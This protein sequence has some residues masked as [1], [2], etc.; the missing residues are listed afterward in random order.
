[1]LCR[2]FFLTLCYLLGFDAVGAA[3][4]VET[5]VN[6]ASHFPSAQ[7][8]PKRQDEVERLQFQEFAGF[9]RSRN[10][11]NEL[12]ELEYWGLLN[13]H[14]GMTRSEV[15]EAREDLPDALLSLGGVPYEWRFE[16]GE[17]ARLVAVERWLVGALDESLAPQHAEQVRKNR[18]A[19]FLELL[20]VLEDRYGYPS[21]NYMR[22]TNAVDAARVLAGMGEYRVEWHGLE[23]SV[24]IWVSDEGLVLENRQGERSDALAKRNAAIAWESRN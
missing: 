22:P 4:T 1:M 5:T 14:W 19:G 20:E 7:Y 24:S 2:I 21:H 12:P 11:V 6:R 16:F 18:T 15:E 17:E 13:L 10:S 9:I 3:P 23:S 8:D